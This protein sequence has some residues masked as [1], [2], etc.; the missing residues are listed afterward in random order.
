M[1]I[2]NTKHWGWLLSAALLWSGAAAA[3]PAGRIT[4]AE[5]VKILQDEGYR[6]KLETDKEGDPVVRTKMSGVHVDVF[7]YDC[8]KDGCGSLQLSSGL[9]LEDG[10]SFAVMNKFNSEFRYA[11]GFLDDEMDPY[12]QFDFE[13]LHTAHAE[14]I[15]SQ[16]GLWEDVLGEFLKATGFHDDGAAEDDAEEGEPRAEPTSA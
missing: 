2:A 1:A 6:A 12:L 14:H 16:I 9:D 10:S 15:A 8:E 5:L 4:G 11:H 7:F 3:D 13:I